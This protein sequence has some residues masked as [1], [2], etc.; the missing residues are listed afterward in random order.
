MWDANRFV[1]P[2]TGGVTPRDYTLLDLSLQQTYNPRV[3]ADE[4]LDAL[5][6]LDGRYKRET[7]PLKEYLSEFAYLRQRVRIEVDYLTALAFTANLFRPLTDS[8]V[9]WLGS[10]ASNFSISDAREIKEFERTTRH[11]VKAIEYLLRARLA[12]SS[13]AV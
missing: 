7:A 4:F 13:L 11:D 6:P 12:S 3:P 1:T 9:A 8:E 2:A 5:S 10:F